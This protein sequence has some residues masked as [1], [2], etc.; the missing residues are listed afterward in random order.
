MDI[1]DDH[2]LLLRQ[3]I[4]IL[5]IKPKTLFAARKKEIVSNLF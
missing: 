2:Y 4:S 3:P 5:Y 1:E